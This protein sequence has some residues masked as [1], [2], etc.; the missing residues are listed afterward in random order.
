MGAAQFS[1]ITKRSSVVHTQY[2]S[3][4]C[5]RMYREK[6][7]NAVDRLLI[8]N[9]GLGT[10]VFAQKE[11]CASCVIYVIYLARDGSAVNSIG[12]LL[13]KLSIHAEDLSAYR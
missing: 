5:S 11:L 13:R 10:G 9:I 3:G 1:L 7:K 2:I 8:K 6:K 12:L 4:D